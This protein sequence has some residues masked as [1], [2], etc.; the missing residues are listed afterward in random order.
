MTKNRH[1]FALQ[2]GGT[3]W[4][5][6][7]DDMRLPLLPGAAVEPHFERLPTLPDSPHTLV[8]RVGTHSMSSMRIRHFS[9]HINLRRTPSLQQSRDRLVVLRLDR[10]LLDGAGLVE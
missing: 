8:D 6:P 5:R 9:G 2:V 7:V 3:Y 4:H 1:L 10:Q